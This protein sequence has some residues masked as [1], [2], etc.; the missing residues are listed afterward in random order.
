MNYP[1]EIFKEL[2]NIGIFHSNP[3]INNYMIKDNKI[4]IIDFGSATEINTKLIKL[5]GTNTPNTKIMTLELINT[6]IKLNLPSSSW[7]YLKK[8]LTDEDINSIIK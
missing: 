8:I 7:K 3:N 1:L 5:L 4:Y 6:L 2:D